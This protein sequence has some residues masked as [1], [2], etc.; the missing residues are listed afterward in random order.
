VTSNYGSRM[1]SFN[2]RP[3][4]VRGISVFS[5]RTKIAGRYVS[6]CTMQQNGSALATLNYT[7]DK[8]P[9]PE[10]YFYEPPPGTLVRPPG[11]DPR[12]MQIF[13]GW[14]HM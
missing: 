10:V 7:A 12:E 9:A 1:R 13:D 5:K 4:K 11:D 14:V 3:I 8:E 6:R 2:M